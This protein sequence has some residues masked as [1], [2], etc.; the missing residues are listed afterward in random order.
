MLGPSNADFSLTITRAF[1]EALQAEL[2]QYQ[3]NLTEKSQNLSDLYSIEDLERKWNNAK[4]IVQ[5]IEAKRSFLAFADRRNSQFQEEVQRAL[6]DVYGLLEHNFT[7]VLQQEA[8]KIV[9]ILQHFV[10]QMETQASHFANLLRTLISNYEQRSNA[11][12]HLNED[13]INGEAIFTRED[14]DACYR[15][16]LLKANAARN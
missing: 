2:N 11:L 5:D 6:Q 15:G 7:Y 14:S 8:L 1:L 9:G 4:Q 16:L 12:E 13:E 10:Q 3:R